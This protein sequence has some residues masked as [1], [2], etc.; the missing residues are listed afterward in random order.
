MIR[1]SRQ[2]FEFLRLN[3]LLSSVFSRHNKKRKMIEIIYGS[4]KIESYLNTLNTILIVFLFPVLILS[5]FFTIDRTNFKKSYSEI[6]KKP[7]QT[8]IT[9]TNIFGFDFVVFDEIKCAFTKCTAQKFA[10]RPE[11]TS[12]S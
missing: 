5:I 10:K 4:V 3:S 2:S 6:P 9:L 12:V 1:D 11:S 7:D 8:S